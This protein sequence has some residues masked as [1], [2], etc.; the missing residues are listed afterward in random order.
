MVSW[1]RGHFNCQ[2]EVETNVLISRLL[3]WKKKKERKKWV[4][5]ISKDKQTSLG[6]L[7]KKP[8]DTV[9]G[10]IARIWPWEHLRGWVPLKTKPGFPEKV[11]F[12]CS[13]WSTSNNT[14]GLE[15]FTW[16]L[17]VNSRRYHYSGE[18]FGWDCNCGLIHL[19]SSHALKVLSHQGRCIQASKISLLIL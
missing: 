1:G 13:T 3:I 17:N 10:Y 12:S 5:V 9:S 7:C 16:N 18:R 8:K 14:I 19:T 4:K 15:N 6:I 2:K 11:M